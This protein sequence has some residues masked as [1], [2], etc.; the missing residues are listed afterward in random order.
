MI[1]QR[2]RL[3]DVQANISKRI[4][5]RQTRPLTYRLGEVPGFKQFME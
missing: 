1:R 4:G 3:S 2:V 5:G